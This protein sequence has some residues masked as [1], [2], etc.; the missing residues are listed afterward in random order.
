MDLVSDFSD[1]VMKIVKDMR[2]HADKS[3]DRLYLL[4][5]AARLEK[6]AE[7]YANT[8][9]EIDMGEDL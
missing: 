8:A 5:T 1:D 2:K 6:L 7:S 9:W 4:N 3:N